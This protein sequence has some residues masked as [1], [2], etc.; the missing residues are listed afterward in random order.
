MAILSGLVA[1][2]A[3]LG[4]AAISSKASKKAT[5]KAVA[6]QQ[7][8]TTQ[9]NALAREIYGKNEGYLAPSIAS[10]QQSN[11]A[12]NA[13]LG[14]GDSAEVDQAYDRFRTSSGFQSVFD[15]GMKALSGQYRARGA[16]QSS[17]YNK[18]SVRFGQE[19][20]TNRLFLPYASLLGDQRNAGLGAASALAGVGQNFSNSV[21]A[22]NNANAS[23]IGN[24]ALLKAQNTNSLVTGL[25]G[26]I[27]N[28][29][30]QF[31]SSYRQPSGGGSVFQTPSYVPTY[32]D[33]GGF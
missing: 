31:G 6:A 23:A 24:A 7:D 12:L 14:F 3:A 30:G 8:A 4:G 26:T 5:N 33:R 10:G 25:A 9:N 20:A 28:I 29:A 18:D 15:E 32:R 21:S 19:Q 2:G 1:A 13:L 22:N 17:K 16:S 11:N 27:G